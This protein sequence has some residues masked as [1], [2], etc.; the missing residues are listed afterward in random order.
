MLRVNGVV[1]ERSASRVTTCR[2]SL[3]LEKFPLPF[4]FLSNILVINQR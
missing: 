1:R 2:K 4:I 3:S